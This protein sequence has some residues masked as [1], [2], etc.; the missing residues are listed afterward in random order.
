MENEMDVEMELRDKLQKAE[1]CLAVGSIS[2]PWV[3]L[4][5]G[6]TGACPV[7]SHITHATILT[8]NS[9]KILVNTSERSLLLDLI[10]N[11]YPFRN[12]CLIGYNLWCYD[13][14]L[15]RKRAR[16]NSI[17][18]NFGFKKIVDLRTIISGGNRYSRGKLREY[19]A[20]LGMC[21][22]KTGWLKRHHLVHEIAYDA[23]GLH[24]YLM[25][26]CRATYLLLQFLSGQRPRCAQ[27]Q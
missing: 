6:G 13:L 22:E 3:I 10:D 15:I 5:I 20:L 2:G 7:T 27:D 17:S 23:P 25:A 24:D 21:F 26:D 16:A 1:G 12:G 14:P 8:K 4:D 19:A 9:E 11:L 18:H